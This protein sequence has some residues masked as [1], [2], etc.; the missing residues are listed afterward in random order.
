[1]KFKGFIFDMDGVLT[2][3]AS[4]YFPFMKKYLHNHSV[5]ITDEDISLLVGFAFE[6]KTQYLNEKYGLKIDSK[7]FVEKVS[8]KA[9]EKFPETLKPEQG[10]VELIQELKSNKI[11]IGLATANAPQN[12]EVILNS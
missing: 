12:V 11:K 7:E 8:V 1:M 5:D 4:T 9:R 10:A 6:E 2:D 3:T